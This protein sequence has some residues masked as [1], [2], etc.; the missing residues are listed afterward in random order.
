METSLAA[1]NFDLFIVE[2]RHV[3]SQSIRFAGYHFYGMLR[4]PLFAVP[5]PDAFQVVYVYPR[6]AV[7]L[8]YLHRINRANE[9]A[10]FASFAEFHV[11]PGMNPDHFHPRLL[12]PEGYRARL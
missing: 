8:F 5:A 2:L 10:S 7:L 12:S 9:F 6:L 3:R 11:H 1:K 4:A